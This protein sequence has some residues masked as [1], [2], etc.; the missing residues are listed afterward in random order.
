M[1]L[2]Q[3]YYAARVLGLPDVP[4]AVREDAGRIALDSARAPHLTGSVVLSVPDPILLDDLD[5]RDARRL[6]L[7]VYPESHLE[8]VYT[9]WVEQRRNRALN[10][11]ATNTTGWLSNQVTTNPS[12]RG[13]TPPIAHPL[14]IATAVEQRSTGTNSAL[15]TLY[16]LDSLANTGTPARAIGAWVLVTEPGYR[17]YGVD[18]PANAW[19]FIR[20]TAIIAAGAYS[21]FFVNRVSGSSSTTVRAYVTGA[22][23][24]TGVTAV[25]EPFDG[26]TDPSGVLSR[27]RWLGAA[28]A[29]ASV[30]E[31]RTQTGW[32][33]VPDGSP[34]SFDLG[35]REATPTRES[36]TV[37]LQLAS[38]EAVLDDY[39]QLADD[40]GPRAHQASLR[41]VVNY[42]LGKIGAA[43]QPGPTDADVTA[44]WQVVNQITN[45]RLA[46]DAVGWQTGS[47]ASSGGR[48]VMNT[49]LPPVGNTAYRWTASAGESN[50]VPVT[51]RYRVTPGKWYVFFAYICSGTA[52]QA[53]AAIQW[54]S[55]GG[56]VA[57]STALGA[58]VNSD[59]T[60]FR[61]VAVIAKCPPGAEEAVPYVSTLANAAGNLHYATMSMLYEGDE[62]VEY[63]DGATP[64][65]AR[66]EYEFQAAAHNSTST[67]TPTV[68]RPPAALT[69]R[70]GVSGLQ[71]L[72]PLV[73]ASGFR[74]VCDER[75]R[76]TLRDASYRETG[77]QT[78]RERVNITQASEQLSRSAEDWFDGIVLAYTWTDDDGIEQT[79]YDTYAIPGATKII[80]REIRAPYP[81]PGR[82]QYAVTRA[83]GRGRTVTA[84]KQADWTEH[85]EQTFSALLD[86][87]P[88]QIGTADRVEFDIGA[89]TVTTTSRTTD[90]PPSAWVLIPAGDSWLDSP[91]G[92]SW[93]EEAI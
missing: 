51:S 79:M 88:I 85:A 36:A 14:G 63:F 24:E 5:P 13:V 75:R 74:L 34:R 11:R 61:Q 68:E 65:T 40:K 91:V 50:V 52:R 57:S 37:T 29:S 28:N 26:G 67:R 4:V 70:A 20:A 66:Y 82:A 80:R 93:T 87:T 38:D 8:P 71:F 59:V 1:T 22:V 2:A 31:T 15:V 7:D 84:T 54:W 58:L 81:G 12:I 92:E 55:A 72:A 60:A 43:L 9:P 46:L 19:M 21:S 53:R 35:I 41:G 39:A 3:P 86:G 45:P 33:Q 25:G 78:F 44:Y 49:P 83:Q 56:S 62:L 42:V 17:A 10:P 16:N 89:N 77:T 30:M 69:W 76:W 6:V 27:T 90:T 47:G 73:Q 18:L 48:V 23:V 32:E 64:D